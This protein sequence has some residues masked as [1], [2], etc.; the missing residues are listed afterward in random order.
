MRRKIGFWEAF[1][2]GV[3]GMIGGGIFAVL[4]LSIQLSKSSAFI[5]FIIAGIVA[6]LTSYSYSKLS[7]RFPSEGGT[8]EFMVKAYGTGIFSG[9]LNI[10]LLLSYIVMISLYAYAFGSY[11]ANIIPI[12]KH[13]LISFV[14]IFF[15]II[16]ALGAFVSGKTED[17][18]VMFKLG[19]LITVVISGLFFVNAQRLYNWSDAVSIISGGMII[20]LAYEG[21]ELIANTGRDVEELSILPK[22]FYSSVIVVIAV[23]VS[24]A[25]VTVGTLSY[26]TIMEARDYALAIAAEPSLG[27]AGFLLVTLAA[28]A[29]TS[30]A[31]NATL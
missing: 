31:I 13:A 10:L 4:G 6:L 3:G 29:S 25:I 15:A 24:I 16:N 9:T 18:L 19:V 1:S 7:V 2:I 8:I 23:Y 12:S 22:A 11:A 27:K 5:S 17:I 26:S 28:I 30:S 14:I 21:F 20:F